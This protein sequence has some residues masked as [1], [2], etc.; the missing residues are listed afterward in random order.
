[1][2][3]I[4]R[5]KGWKKICATISA[6]ATIWAM[7]LPVEVKVGKS[8]IVLVTWLVAQGAEDVAEKLANGKPKPEEPAERRV[9]K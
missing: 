2:K 8:V 6:I 5:F 4:D 1:M 9:K 7:P 3:F